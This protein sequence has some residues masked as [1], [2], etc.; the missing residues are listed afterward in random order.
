MSM[1]KLAL[2]RLKKRKLASLRRGSKIGDFVI[3][4]VK[5]VRVLF[6]LVMVDFSGLIGSGSIIS[7]ES[8]S[9][10]SF[11]TTFAASFFFST[12][13]GVSFFFSITGSFFFS[14]TESF[15][16]STITSFFFSTGAGGSSS[17]SSITIS[18]EIYNYS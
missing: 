10:S 13:T 3:I 7:I 12:T 18:Y 1:K 6:F 9:P 16:F 15:F 4:S 17:S 5:R 11:A 8:S 14:T 2:S